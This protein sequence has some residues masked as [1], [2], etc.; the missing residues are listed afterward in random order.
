[1][2]GLFAGDHPW[3]ETDSPDARARIARG[4][5]A[6]GDTSARVEVRLAP[7]AQQAPSFAFRKIANEEAM[8]AVLDRP[9]TDRL[10]S[11]EFRR[12]EHELGTLFGLLA[13]GD[14]VELERRLSVS[15]ADDMLASRF[16]RLTP[17]RRARLLT[18]LRH[19]R[20]RAVVSVSDGRR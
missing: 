3:R 11:E 17:E 20:H 9:T 1:M 19:A 12:K 4:D 16:A 8:V 2:K 7:P 18:F 13:P 10:P 6:V 5:E 15:S 14:S